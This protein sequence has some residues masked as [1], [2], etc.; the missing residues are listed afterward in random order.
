[1]YNFLF[2]LLSLKRKSAN[3]E[4]GESYNK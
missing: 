4:Y 3:I 2:A 1:M